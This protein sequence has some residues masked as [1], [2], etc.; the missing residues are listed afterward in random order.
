MTTTNFQIPSSIIQI[1][2]KDSIQWDSLNNIQENGYYAAITQPLYTISGLWQEIFRTFTYQLWSTNYNFT[3]IIANNITGI[4]LYLVSQRMDR[5]QDYIIQLC[6]NGK[7]IGNNYANLMGGNNQLYGGMND[8]WGTTLTI[9][10]IMNPTFG[11]VIE[12]Q[13]NLTIPHSDI[14]YVEQIGLRVYYE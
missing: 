5:C 14:M 4:E 6:L 11:I 1:A 9:D 7:L 13:S 10:D 3:N 8:M 12:F 2:D